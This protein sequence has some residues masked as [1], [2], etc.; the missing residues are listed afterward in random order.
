MDPAAETYETPKFDPDAAILG[1]AE[2]LIREGKLDE[3]IKLIQ[4][5]TAEKPISGIKLSERYYNLLK[6]KKRKAELLEYAERHLDILT[7]GSEK[8]KAI[9]V[10]TECRMADPGFCPT[11]VTLFKVAG[12]LN[13]TGKTK[14]AIALYNTIAKSYP[15]NP[16][17][18]K[19]YFR[20]AQIFHDRLMNREQAIKV[21]D[22][23]LRKYPEHDI[24]PQAESFL[25]RL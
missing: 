25:A 3:A 19:A 4:T 16:L 18:P 24:S 12:C 21:L 7:E 8:R 5:M 20:I 22:L 15:D 10:F 14:A 6:M 1:R 23:L 9:A 17:V 13:E 11:A 2:P